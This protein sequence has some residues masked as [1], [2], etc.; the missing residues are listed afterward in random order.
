[1]YGTDELMCHK[2]QSVFVRVYFYTN[3]APDEL[4]YHKIFSFAF[5]YATIKQRILAATTINHG[6]NRSPFGRAP[7]PPSFTVKN[8]LGQVKI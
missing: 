6:K 2:M 7:T 5:L 3:A 1:M 4:M 8:N